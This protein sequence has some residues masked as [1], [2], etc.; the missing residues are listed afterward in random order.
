MLPRD[1]ATVRTLTAEVMTIEQTM[2]AR[3][4]RCCPGATKFSDIV[5]VRLLEELLPKS[6]PRYFYTLRCRHL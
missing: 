4:Y 2:H 5:L 6:F 1:E 3:R